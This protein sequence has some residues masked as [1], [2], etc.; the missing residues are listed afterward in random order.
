M[1]LR[2]QLQMLRKKMSQN[3]VT[4]IPHGGSDDEDDNFGGTPFYPDFSLSAFRDAMRVDTTIPNGRVKNAVIDAALKTLHDLSPLRDTHSAFDT[5]AD[6]PADEMDGVS[7]LVH[8]YRSAVYNEAKASLTE[9]YRDFDST[10]SGHEEAD[11]LE[12][13]IEDYR[14]VARENIRAMLG[15]PRATIRI[16]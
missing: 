11:K 5:L 16:L 7:V 10:Q 13:T 4:I 9:K 12:M 14:R 8:R 15:K 1:T 2:M 3:S 6:V